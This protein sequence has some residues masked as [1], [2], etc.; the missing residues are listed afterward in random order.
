MTAY[1]V[2]TLL[3]AV[4]LEPDVAYVHNNLGMALELDGQPFEALAAYRRALGCDPS[5]EHGMQNL[6]RLEPTLP[7][8]EPRIV[9]EASVTEVEVDAAG[10]T[11]LGTAAEETGVGSE[12]ASN[13][14][15]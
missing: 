15:N 9:L 6:A 8:E 11:V 14:A 12:T 5:H 2:A 4:E 10:E 13:L 7:T 3:S 1:A